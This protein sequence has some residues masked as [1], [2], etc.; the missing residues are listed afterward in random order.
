MDHHPDVRASDRDREA[1]AERLRLAL[2]EGCLDLKEFND[3]LGLAYQ[4]LTRRQLADLLAD[5]PTERRPLRTPAPRGVPRWLKLLWAGWAAVLTVNIAIWAAVSAA[6]EC[7][8]EFWPKGLFVP[9]LILTIVT[10]VTIA[11]SRD[12]IAEGP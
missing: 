8:V 1:A 10:V 5:L 7:P 9:G 6:E 3:R 2:E 4:S 12:A 11:R